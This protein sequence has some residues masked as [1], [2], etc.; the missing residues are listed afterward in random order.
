[1]ASTKSDYVQEN[2]SALVTTVAS[3][4]A[5]EQDSATIS[6]TDN[7]EESSSTLSFYFKIA[8][9]VLGVVG[10]IA[11]GTTLWALLFTKQVMKF[12]FITIV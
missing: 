8:V 12:L 6:S 4:M 3:G 11:N 9:I 10:T 1:M 7:L 2:Q 5:Y